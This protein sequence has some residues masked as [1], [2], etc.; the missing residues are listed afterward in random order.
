MAAACCNEYI[1]FDCSF[2]RPRLRVGDGDDDDDEG[3]DEGDDDSDDDD[4]DDDES[5]EL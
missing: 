4:D 2:G 3:D 5:I 1:A